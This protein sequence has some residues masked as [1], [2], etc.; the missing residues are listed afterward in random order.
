M[1]DDDDEELDE[2]REEIGRLE[3]VIEEAHD[4]L[5][6]YASAAKFRTWEISSRC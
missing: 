6:Q 4:L 1:I 5:E 2:L 3:K